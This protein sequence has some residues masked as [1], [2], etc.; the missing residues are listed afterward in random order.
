LDAQQGGSPSPFDRNLGTKLASRAVEWLLENA[1]ANRKPDGKVFTKN[2][3]TAAVLGLVERYVVFT[4]VEKLRNQ[5]DFVHRLPKEQ[6]WLKLRPLLRILAKHDSIYETS[7]VN[8][9]EECQG[10]L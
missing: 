9:E 6:W 4:P 1:K 2:S 5:T 8:I 3:S 10:E 7:A